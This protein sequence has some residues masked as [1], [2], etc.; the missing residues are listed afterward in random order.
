[1][2]KLLA[3]SLALFI[4]SSSSIGYSQIVGGRTNSE[5]QPKISEA[6]KLSGG[7][8]TGDV[9]HMTG[10]YNGNVTLGTV[11][12]PSGLSYSLSIN[13]NSSFSF[14]TNMPM[15]AGVPYGDG[16]SPNI[17]TISVETDVLHRFSKTLECNEENG[18]GTSTINTEPNPDGLT[19][20]DEGDLYWF[21]PMVNIPGVA[22]GRAIFKYI[23]V[24]DS[25]C[26]VFVLNK[27]ESP[28][29]IRFYGNSWTI[30]IADGTSYQLGTHLANYYAPS[31]KRLLNYDHID[32][33]G[34]D[35]SEARSAIINGAY[36][37]PAKI[38]N[39]IEPKISHS[40]WYCDL[41]VNQ[42]YPLQGIRFSYETFGK[43]NFF[44]EFLQP[45]YAFI[46]PAIFNATTLPYA[47]DCS[48]YTDIFLKKVHSYVM[49]SALDILELD[50]KALDIPQAQEQILNPNFDSDVIPVDALYNSKVISSYGENMEQNFNEW[51]RFRHTADGTNSLINETNP[52]LHSGGYFYREAA[53]QGLNANELPFDHSFLE[54]KRFDNN[55]IYPG[56]TYEIRTKITRP[57]GT[58]LQNGNGTV[59]IA[60][61]TS[62]NQ[63][64]GNVSESNGPVDASYYQLSRGTEI[65]STF[66]MALKW[67]MGWQQGVLN[68][69]NF[70]VM[71]NLPSTFD[72][73]NIQIGPGNSDIDFGYNDINL[74]TPGLGPNA[75]NCYPQTYGQ[76][77][78][79]SGATIPSN[80]GTGHPWGMMVPIYNK[81]ALENGG[82]FGSAASPEEL[83]TNWWDAV[84]FPNNDIDNI[85]TKFDE[86]VKLKEVQ[87]IRYSKSAYML[88]G[89]RQYRINGELGGPITSGKKLVS[90]KKLDYEVRFENIIKNYDYSEN[91]TVEI[92]TFNNRKRIIILLKSITEVP[93][94]GNL[95][96]LNYNLA[97]PTIVLKTTLNYSKIVDAANTNHLTFKQA[98]PY[99]GLNQYLL[100]EYID[101]LGG[102]TQI[103]YYPIGLAPTR[104]VNNHNYNPTC[105]AMIYR[106]PFGTGHSYTAHV[107]VKYLIKNDE[108]DQ[109]FT[110][111]ILDPTSLKRWEYVYDLTSGISNPQE[112]VINSNHFNGNFHHDIEA[113]YSKIRVYN[114]YLA[115][116]ERTYTDFEYYGGQITL[117]T[118]GSWNLPSKEDYL[119]YG[120]LKTTKTYSSTGILHEETIHNYG[121]TLAFING[122]E[123]PNLWREQLGFDDLLVRDYE[124]KDLY[125]N[126]EVSLVNEF[127]VTVTGEAAYPYLDIVFNGKGSGIEE[128]PKFLEFYFFNSLK[129]TN[130]DYMFNSY[131]VKKT[132]EINRTYENGLTKQSNSNVVAVPNGVSKSANPFGGGKENPI[133]NDPVKDT[134]IKMAI[135][136]QK[137]QSVE[138]LIAESPLSDSVLYELISETGITSEK[139]ADIL[140]LQN[141]VSNE[142]WKKVITK[143]SEFPPVSVEKMIRVQA[144]FSDEILFHLML[145]TT[146]KTNDKLVEQI[147]TKNEYLS[148]T[149]V[150]EM[151]NAQRIFPG[152]SYATILDKQTQFTED[153]LS[154]IIASGNLREAHLVK[155]LKNQALSDALFL[156]ILNDNRFKEQTV[157]RLLEQTLSYPSDAVLIALLNKT[158]SYTVP[159]L[160]RIMASADRELGSDVLLAIDSK[161]ST[162]DAKKIKPPIFD[163]NGL[164]KACNNPVLTGRIYIETKTEYEYYEAHYTGTAIGKAYEILL[165]HRSSVDESSSFPK[166][167]DLS[168]YGFGHGTRTIDSLRLKHEPSWQVFSVK[169]SSPH[170]PGAYDRQEYFYWYDLQNRYDRYWFN[171]DAANT[172]L[173]FLEISVGM[174]STILHDTLVSNNNWPQEYSDF[175]PKLPQFDGMERSRTYG[176]RSIAFQKSSFSKNTRDQKPL[177]NSEYYYY[178]RRWKFTDLPKQAVI[179]QEDELACGEIP[180]GDDPAP[181]A[182]CYNYKYT[183]EQALVSDLPLNFCAWIVGG[184]V[185]FCPS[186]ISALSCYPGAILLQ[187][188]LGEPLDNDNKALPVADALSKSLQLRSIIIQLDTIHNS[189]DNDFYVKRIDPKN[190]YVTDFYM[191]AT[192]EEDENNF[193]AP[194]KMLMP[195]DNLN[196]RKILER[197]RYLQPKIEQNQVGLKT[198]YYY[199]ISENYWHINQNCTGPSLGNYNSTVNKNIGLPIRIT[200]GYDRVVQGDSMATDYEYNAIGQVKK[201][202]EPSGKFMEYA[203]DNFHR[204]ITVKENGTRILAKTEYHIW[205]QNNLL[206]FNQRTNQN[207]VLNF[208]YS[209]LDT[210]NLAGTELQKS[211]LDPLGREHS[212]IQAYRSGDKLYATHSGTIQQDNWSRVNKAHKNYQQIHTILPDPFF[213]PIALLNASSNIGMAFSETMFENDPKS[214]AKKMSNYGVDILTNIHVVKNNYAIANNVYTSCELGLTLSELKLIMGHGNTSAFRFYRSSMLDQDNKEIIEYSN[215]IGQKVATLAYS[216][217]NEK[218]VTLFVY[219]S[220][221]NLAKVINPIKQQRNYEF[222]MLGQLVKETSVDAGVK[223]YMYNKQ[224]LVSV[225]QD[226]LGRTHEINAV[227]SPYYRVF[228]YD[229][230]GRLIRSGRTNDVESNLTYPIFNSLYD[231]LLY[232]TTFVGE[233]PGVPMYNGSVPFYFDYTYTNISSLD[234]LANYDGIGV[235]G[236][237]GAGPTLDVKKISDFTTRFSP[238]IAEK[239][240]FYGDNALLPNIGKVIKTKSYDNEGKNIQ[241]I[242]FTYNATDQVASQI[243]KFHPTLDLNNNPTSGVRT[244]VIY[245][246]AYNYRGSLL[247][248]KADVDNDTKIDIHYFNKYD[249]LNRLVAVYAASAEVPDE[250]FASLLVSFE[251]DDANGLI[252]KKK[253]FI[254]DGSGMA[255]L[256]NEII[257]KFDQRDRL[258]GILAGQDPNNLLM[259]YKLFY[260]DNSPLYVAGTVETV[261]ADQNWNG[262]INGT[263]MTY[264]AGVS[265]FDLPTLYGYKYDKLN[266]LTAADATVGDFVEDATAPQL[267][268]SYGIGD[269]TM[270]YDKIGNIKT[271]LRVLRN[272]DLTPNASYTAL[273]HFNYTYQTG[274]NRLLGVVG[275]SGSA[276][277]NYTYD[278]NG[279]MLT[280]SYKQI[281]STNYGRGAYAYN[282]VKNGENISYLYS[283]TDQRTYKKVVTTAETT[284]EYYL[285]DAF[286]KTIAIENRITNSWEY[287]VISNERDARLKPITTGGTARFIIDE[288]NFF[289]YDHLGNTR[290]TY[291]PIAYTTTGTDNRIDYLADYY[292][293]GK[294]LREYVYGSKERYLTT[295]HERDVETGL[296]YRGARYY[297]S[298]VARFL[299]LD[300]LAADF[301]SWSAYNYVMGNPV[302]LTDP[303]GKNPTNDALK[304]AI[305]AAAKQ[306]TLAEAKKMEA[307]GKLTPAKAEEVNEKINPSSLQTNALTGQPIVMQSASSEGNNSSSTTG[308]VVGSV[309]VAGTVAE[310]SSGTFR[311]STTTRG[312]SPKYYGT[313]WGGN[314]YVSTYSVSTFGKAISGGSTLLSTGMSYYDIATDNASPITYADAAVGSAGTMALAANYFYGVEI[315][316]VGEAVA[317]YGIMRLAWD[318]SYDYGR[319]NGPSTWFGDNDFKYFE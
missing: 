227:S 228:K 281:T 145:H 97:D 63:T 236:F 25:K 41:I 87:L 90:Q 314:Q 152:E 78:I 225:M 142:V 12:T 6:T 50:Y 253:H 168:D 54:S 47:P 151:N 269:E 144:Y 127:G 162:K 76:R 118:N 238:V 233:Q 189:L 11:S 53:P 70:F 316:V 158:P 7:G 177:M 61:V 72:G 278:A 295:Q 273:D 311:I 291:T 270:T 34:T 51:A 55:L 26:A 126:E 286:G 67:Q 20:S 196:V 308:K 93:V 14:S 156:Q 9:N 56:D 246:P 91:Q 258:T 146:H 181:C 310:E 40:V 221:G 260:D 232:E 80:F 123:R 111:N 135:H 239:E 306:K 169:T 180:P 250:S 298:D 103:E 205:D 121:H 256:A 42:N 92:E 150:K 300:P 186:A 204:L 136:E 137:M 164:T 319:T 267:L 307:K 33:S 264:N 94:D 128:R 99:A 65:F 193:A 132:S 31:N 283:V 143:I 140:T 131:F 212:S 287:F 37:D 317:L 86:N 83:Y 194:V 77:D 3:L 49:E 210:V 261:N 290:V 104:F 224:G 166:T 315:P 190:R 18:F 57:D 257:Y 318:I 249:P 1:M 223:R 219:N 5:Q 4:G 157:T 231:P 312:F 214:R 178:D 108:T 255:K 302:L 160:T 268:E 44:Q 113:S 222:N 28:V 29:E 161:F 220:Y 119:L 24:A 155:I 39:A 149:V 112:I 184:N 200:I 229:D 62:E 32:D 58:H 243:I 275:L 296:D 165:G 122:Y 174:G 195:F 10:E 19:A 71:P 203:F 89:V 68:T 235:I 284:E 279:N 230:F 60:I 215:A 207:Y 285:T 74:N 173:D 52:Y 107:A 167:I 154:K 102:I 175:Y 247:E 109:V 95:F 197:N 66:N 272:P 242:E 124:Y 277:R 266:R 244:S 297:D 139:K 211:F 163:G 141:G 45:R 85:P 116:G 262:N 159:S 96:A 105:N 35:Q 120:Q 289:L 240:T 115:S 303:D 48:A 276:S 69:S 81:I 226:E 130:P 73:F 282:M 217:T 293:Y 101:N 15:T 82:L 171:F 309:G 292:P 147:F 294:V 75:L 216:A 304:K 185:I 125:L 79:K 43:F 8:F 16:W 271:L 305:A 138:M 274:K 252:Q 59:D 148:D 206:T 299:S 129:E 38:K 263:L 254:D 17:P 251:Y 98:S 84:P 245:Y 64:V 172:N 153:M 13:Y 187:C 248:E 88:Q 27:F 201:I 209:G 114:P 36:A 192:S 199:E 280:D 237:T 202:T 100:T 213:S 301:P 110:N 106:K 176:N 117:N 241:T 30:K 183:T 2:K 134:P 313:G 218:I 23:D 170:L 133:A 288:V 182:D 198:R 259:H 265:S 22:S 208:I 234:W 191:G 179:V 46:S 21:S 188:N